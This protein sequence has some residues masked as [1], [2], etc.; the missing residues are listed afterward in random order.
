MVEFE[1][2]TATPERFTCQ[3]EDGIVAGWRWIAPKRPRLLFCHANGF[4]ASAYKNMLSRLS[5]AFEVLAI[6]MRGHGRTTLPAEPERLT[7][8]RIYGNDVRR[9]LDD[10]SASDSRAFVVAGHSFGAVAGAIAANGDDRVVGVALIEPVALP[11]LASAIWRSPFARPFVEASSL[12]KG[13]RSRRAEWPDRRS[14]FAAYE[15]KALFSTWERGA[16]ENYLEDGLRDIGSGVSL[17]C[18]PAWEAA[19]FMSHTSSFWGAVRNRS[20]PMGVLRASRAGSTCPPSS[21]A[22][23]RR[24]GVN[25]STIAGA[26][27]LAP[28][29]NSADSAAFLGENAAAWA[30]LR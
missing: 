11:P 29:E 17:S 26:G 20:Q 2:P 13:A 24:N 8:W 4:C 18:L 10:L 25:V 9:V 19:T 7:D 27:H 6:D 28:M 3:F 30:A 1:A 21:L 16:L 5:P 15:R 14:V 12:V 22:R 23:F